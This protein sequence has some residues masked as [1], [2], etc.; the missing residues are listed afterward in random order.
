MGDGSFRMDDFTWASF[1]L[2][3]LETAIGAGLGFALG[4]AAFH[5]QHKREKEAEDEEA[6]QAALDAL[7]RLS[8]AAGLNIE[9]LANLKLQIV[10]DLEP[11][12][13]MMQEAVDAYYDDT[14]PGRASRI[15]G[16]KSMSESL[17]HFYKTIPNVMVMPAPDFREFS[18][19]SHEM[20]AL[21]SFIHRGM[22]TLQEINEVTRM[23]NALIGEHARLGTGVGMTAEQYVYY[24]SM[25][26]GTGTHICQSVDNGIV[27]LK[28]AM[29]QIERYFK[30]KHKGKQY[31]SFEFAPVALELIP[32]DDLFP[33]LRKQ[34]A[35]FGQKE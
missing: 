12:V 34:M 17:Q 27:F 13:A 26:C 10:K 23:H 9:A 16:M 29:E 33:E 28:M 22:G 14:T 31:L 15:P 3:I 21:T 32:K 19:L 8:Q 25:L 4:L 7:N 5:Y 30:A 2:S 35:T 1:G 11:E 6:Q 24:W 20:P 18:L